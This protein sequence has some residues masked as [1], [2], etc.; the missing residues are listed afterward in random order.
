MLPSAGSHR[1]RHSSA[2]EKQGPPWSTWYGPP[3]TLLSRRLKPIPPFPRSLI[4]T[5]ARLQ[6]SLQTGETAE[7]FPQSLRPADGPPL[8]AGEGKPFSYVTALNRVSNP[9]D[10]SDS[11]TA[12][13]GSRAWGCSVT[14]GRGNLAGRRRDKRSCHAR[15]SFLQTYVRAGACDM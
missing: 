13:G 1:V 9:T 5:S 10:G 2:T 11:K 14:V 7:S 8:A 4:I 6:I 3:V 12:R 15:R